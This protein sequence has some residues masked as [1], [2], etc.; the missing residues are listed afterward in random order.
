MVLKSVLK[1]IRKFVVVCFLSFL[2]DTAFLLKPSLHSTQT[3]S[4]FIDLERKRKGIYLSVMWKTPN[5]C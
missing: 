3:F 2:P 1:M 4:S 5:F